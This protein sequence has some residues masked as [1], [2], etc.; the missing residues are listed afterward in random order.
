MTDALDCFG[1]LLLPLR[2]LC[3]ETDKKY[4]TEKIAAIALLITSKRQLSP[5]WTNGALGFCEGVIN[6]YCKQPM[7]NI[8]RPDESKSAFLLGMDKQL[9]QQ[10]S[11]QLDPATAQQ[12]MSA[13]RSI[14]K[15]KLGDALT[16]LT[17]HNRGR[18]QNNHQPIILAITKQ[19]GCKTSV[20]TTICC[21]TNSQ[22]SLCILYNLLG[23]GILKPSNKYS[24]TAPLLYKLLEVSSTTG[25]HPNSFVEQILRIKKS[26]K[27]TPEKLLKCLADL[28]C[29]TELIPTTYR[30]SLRDELIQHPD[31]W[32]YL[33][34]HMEGHAFIPQVPNIRA[35]TLRL[36]GM[37]IYSDNNRREESCFSDSR[38]YIS[39]H[40]TVTQSNGHV[41]SSSAFADYKSFDQHARIPTNLR[42]WCSYFHNQA[43]YC[44]L[45]SPLYSS[46]KGTN[47]N[48]TNVTI[49]I[50]TNDDGTHTL[51]CKYMFITSESD[52]R[53]FPAVSLKMRLIP[54]NKHASIWPFE[55]A[56]LYISYSN[57]F[58]P[59]PANASNLAPYTFR[60]GNTTISSETSI[61]EVH[62]LF[63]DS[64]ETPVAHYQIPPS[65]Y[66][67]L[68]RITK[69]SQLLYFI[70][71][72]LP[73]AELSFSK[74]R[75]VSQN[76]GM[77]DYQISCL[78]DANN[79][80]VPLLILIRLKAGKIASAEWY[81]DSDSVLTGSYPGLPQH[82]SLSAVQG[83]H[84]PAQRK[85][86][87]S[88][89]TSLPGT[90]PCQPSIADSQAGAAA[91]APR[92]K[93]SFWRTIVFLW[94][95]FKQFFCRLLPSKKEPAFEGRSPDSTDGYNI[96]AAEEV[97]TGNK[98]VNTEQQLSLAAYPPEGGSSKD[99]IE[100][101]DRNC[102]PSA[103]GA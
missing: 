92:S 84:E 25:H 34:P 1:Y 14:I 10:N 53:L 86:I 96:F 89:L 45:G 73:S 42:E 100:N 29:T 60:L 46:G 41:I 13:L 88:A 50:T 101:S 95:A 76:S 67:N 3:C 78:A 102:Y 43:L 62:K 51:L 44:F 48:K 65:E 93:V 36:A 32:R 9:Q 35:S 28:V 77:Q 80:Q 26:N 18:S 40:W 17:T 85:A 16:L 61:L 24:S 98:P 38:H 71:K 97:D 69:I 82:G 90:F 63:K 55:V 47:L 56:D 27:S 83:E 2:Q 7:N 64:L 87:K 11:K 58:L 22:I 30:D 39:T 74:P 75:L 54:N 19:A 66:N 103:V 33:Q 23:W 37:K 99:F 94:E 6:C 15:A 57:F 8:A 12:F 5:Q 68:G 72:R 81:V 31:M 49:A 70:T 59:A 20:P 4:I 91:S 79:Q 21:K 52:G